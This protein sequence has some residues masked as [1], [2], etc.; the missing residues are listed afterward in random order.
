MYCWYLED[1]KELSMSAKPVDRT[2]LQNVV[3]I[4]MVAMRKNVRTVFMVFAGSYLVIECLDK[5][6]SHYTYICNIDCNLQM[7]AGWVGEPQGY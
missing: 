7:C 3:G 4:M 6:F 5:T 1:D 2:G